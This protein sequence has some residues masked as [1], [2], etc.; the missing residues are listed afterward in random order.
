MMSAC[1]LLLRRLSAVITKTPPLKRDDTRDP[2]VK[3]PKRR[4]FIN[5]G[6][7]LWEIMPVEF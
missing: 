3:A 2:N 7:T 1:H 6:S 4:E 5:Q